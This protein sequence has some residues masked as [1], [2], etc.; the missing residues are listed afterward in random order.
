MLK[1]IFMYM[2]LCTIIACSSKEKDNFDPTSPGGNDSTGKYIP[3]ETSSMPMP[4][5]SHAKLTKNTDP[6]T[7]GGQKSSDQLLI[8]DMYSHITDNSS[9]GP[10]DALGIW[11]G[12]FGKNAINVSLTKI[13]GN[14]VEGYS[15]C[16]GNFRRIS[17]YYETENDIVF[18]FQMNEPGTDPYDGVFDFSVNLQEMELIGNWKPFKEKGNTPK[19]YLLT[20]KTFI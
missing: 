7:Y 19:N 2:V 9:Y 12:P 5:K 15:V 4:S 6:R 18:H 17:G 10:I 11:V 8:D 16:A 13:E 14:R 20:N 1:K 3:T